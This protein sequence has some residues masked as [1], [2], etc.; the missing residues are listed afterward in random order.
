MNS[1]KKIFVSIGTFFTGFISKIYMVDA[2]TEDNKNGLGNSRVIQAKYG[3]YTPEPTVGEKI[4]NIS[5]F[6]VPICLFLIG[7]FV[8]LN[9]KITT[10]AKTI[11]IPIL[12]IIAILIYFLI[13]YI[14]TLI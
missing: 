11:I 2:L 7:L 14:I 12:G 1:M 9:K 13:S 10:K 5:K 6:A 4:L 3:V 8:V